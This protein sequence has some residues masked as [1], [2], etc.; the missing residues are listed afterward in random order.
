MTTPIIRPATTADLSGIKAIYDHQVEHAISTFDVEPPPVGY[1]EARLAS[2][3]VGDHLLVAE[4][5]DRPED[6]PGPHVLGYA[7]SSTY[8]PRTA[9][10][11][12]RETSVYLVDG[13][14]GRGIGRALYDDLLARLRADRIHTVLAVVALPN[15]ASEALHRA[16]G[17][18]RVGVLPDVGHKLGRWIDT[19]LWALRLEVAAEQ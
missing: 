15:P 13:A 18:E 17:F 7:Y 6:G 2:T 3:D 11:R 8:R 9:Y 5:G 19:G 12:T 1:W 10:A 4:D 16:C 14:G